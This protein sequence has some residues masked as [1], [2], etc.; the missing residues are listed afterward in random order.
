MHRYFVSS[1][2]QITP[3]TLLLTLRKDPDEARLFSFQPGQYSAIEYRRHG[4][5]SVSRC[6]SIVSSPTEQDTLQF[7]M[8]TRGTY[9]TAL[10]KLVQGD[11]VFVRGPFGGF[12][13]DSSRDERAV[14]IAGGIGITPFISMVRYATTLQLKNH[15]TLLYGVATQDDIPFLDEL[16]KLQSHN[17][18]LRIVYVVGNGPT[19]KLAEKT[20]CSG[21]INEHVLDTYANTYSDATYFICGPPPLM[22]GVVKVLRSKKVPSRRLITEAFSQG[23]NRQ[24]G[25]VLSWPQNMYVLGG[26]GFALG[27]LAIMVADIAK[28]LPNSNVVKGEGVI[29]LLSDQNQREKD[30]D[31]MVN[32]LSNDSEKRGS[33]QALVK[34]QKDASTAGTTTVQDSPA[35]VAPS[36]SAASSG[37]SSGGSPVA[38]PAPSQPVCTTSQSGITT[39]N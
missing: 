33:S 32:R 4:R 38:A 21:F 7:S 23:S 10:T 9:T 18:H 16:T 5:P 28:S 3:S 14:F 25:K 13:F 12:I 24:T 27:A 35:Y 17:P 8:R 11:E 6:F 29:D 20:A 15:I 37:A 26:V 30:L 19:D 31:D 2:D 1:T 22:N 34:A 36:P 39:C